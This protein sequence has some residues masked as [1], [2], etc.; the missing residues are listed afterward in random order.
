MIFIKKYRQIAV[1]GIWAAVGQVV[2]SV[3]LLVGIK[4][5]TSLVSPEVY[6]LLA[7]FV[8]LLNLCS[9]IFARPIIQAG[10]RFYHEVCRPEEL[11][12]MRSVLKKMLW[13]SGTFVVAL[14][15]GGSFFYIRHV[16]GG[17]YWLTLALVS[18]L[19]ADIWRT[20]ESSL[21]NAAR[22]Q[23][24]FA[25][26][27]ASEGWLRPAGAIVF[28]YLMGPVP[29]AILVGYAVGAFTGIAIFNRPDQGLKPGD[30]GNQTED[31][32]QLRKHIL[33]YAGPLFGLAF[34]GWISSTGDRYLLAGMMG[35]QEVGIYAAAYGL[36]MRP[37]MLVE[38]VVELTVRPL[39][40]EAVA[41]GLKDRE[42]RI[43][44]TWLLITGLT[45][46]VGFI[47]VIFMKFWIASFFLGKGFEQSA[48]LMPYI[49]AGGSLLVVSHVLEKPFYAY[50]RTGPVLAIQILVAG[51]SLLAAFLCIRW[52]GL[53]GTAIAMLVYY[54]FQCGLILV[55]RRLIILD[56][57]GQRS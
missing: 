54:S 30:S 5:I 19:I 6:G 31:S 46:A 56:K 34:V 7:L 37:F 26:W 52:W 18:L 32:V 12:L 53:K 42:A 40:F 2:Y 36:I 21:L 39:Y 3:G 50:M 16:S 38:T 8:A 10:L 49:A 44:W 11:F 9:G 55:F 29:D 14:I 15:A 22:N 57:L 4:V 47:L 35:M 23:R 13:R 48:V 1:E 51:F 27:L 17:S 41:A 28:I 45:C 24:Q 25:L 43:L 20:Y 33:E